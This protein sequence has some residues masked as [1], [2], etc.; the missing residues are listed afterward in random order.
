MGCCGKPK[1]K[2]GALA[3]P[4]NKPTDPVVRPDGSLLFTG[5]APNKKGFVHD[6]GNPRRLIPDSV[7]CTFRINS[8]LLDKN[9][10]YSVMNDCIHPQCEHRGLRVTIE[11][12]EVCSLR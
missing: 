1:R 12:C 2:V 6:P 5:I 3:L 7:P 9:G 4:K 8:P 11:I 10:V